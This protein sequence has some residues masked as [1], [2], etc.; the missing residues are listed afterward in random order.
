MIRPKKLS[1]DTNER[2]QQI[3]TLLT[4]ETELEPEPKRSP[5]S[6]YLAQVGRKGG[7]KGGPARARVLTAA[8]RKASAKKAAEARWRKQTT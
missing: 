4:G 1:R 5:R 3:A 7:L 2:A 6:V 8:Q